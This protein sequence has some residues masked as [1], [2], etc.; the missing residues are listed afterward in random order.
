[1]NLGFDPNT[2]DRVQLARV[3]HGDQVEK[4]YAS[5]EKKFQLKPEKEPGLIELKC[6]EKRAAK[7]QRNTSR[8][9]KVRDV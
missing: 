6:S 9:A 1:M 3:L 7:Q 5:V 8:K 4:D 2:V